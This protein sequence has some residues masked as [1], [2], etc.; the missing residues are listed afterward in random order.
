MSI[1]SS[2]GRSPELE[3]KLRAF[4]QAAR[5]SRLQ[6]VAQLRS[7]TLAHGPATFQDIDALMRRKAAIRRELA[8]LDTVL[9]QTRAFWKPGFGA[10]WHGKAARRAAA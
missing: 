7:T 1:P 6:L 5:A 3:H 2:N 4:D 10:G 9:G 8:V